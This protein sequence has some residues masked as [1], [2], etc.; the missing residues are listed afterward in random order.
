[1]RCLLTAPIPLVYLLLCFIKEIPT[2]RKV[3]RCRFKPVEEKLTKRKVVAQAKSLTL[4][5]RELCVGFQA[6]ERR[7]GVPS[8]VIRN[9]F[10]YALRALLAT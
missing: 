2:Q 1:M 3:E 7:V 9:S 8:S 10:G 4:V 6:R 5:D